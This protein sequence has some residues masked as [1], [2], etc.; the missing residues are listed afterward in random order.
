M[1]IT[2]YALNT[3]K[4]IGSITIAVV[5]DLH[6]RPYDKALAALRS[7]CPDVIL[8]PGDI[9]EIATEYMDRRN[10]CGLDFLKKAA[11]IAP[12]YYCYGNHEIY[13]THAGPHR[14]KTPDKVFGEEYVKR[15]VSY[16]VHLIND[17]DC[18]VKL[19]DKKGNEVDL[20]IG[21]LVC[22][23][24]MD[25]ALNSPEPDLNYLKHFSEK[26]GYKILLC[27]YPHYYEKYLKG[28]ALDLVLSGHAHGGQ[29]RIFG[30]GIYAPHQGLFPK[31][32]SG[33]HSKNH[34][35]SRGAANNVK[36]I[37]RLFNHC[38]VLE[39]NITGNKK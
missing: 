28:V 9:V 20:L 3:D 37:P 26:E 39:I 7:I 17:C 34:I 21:G 38:E 19:S 11:E 1:K 31:Y 5:S 36:P 23:R 2:Q 4:F 25:P 33:L 13:H 35:I 6:A 16:G 8:L 29:W 32:T 14:S 15:I 30:Q 12:C 10:Q 18:A 27:H 24:D 22:G